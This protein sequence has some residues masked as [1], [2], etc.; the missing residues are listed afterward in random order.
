MKTIN[1]YKNLDYKVEILKDKD[2]GG[3]VALIPELKGRI[4][5]GETLI[6]A[7][8][9]LED[10]KLSWLEA[11]LEDGYDIPLPNDRQKESNA[12]TIAAINEYYEIHNNPDKYPRYKD[13]KDL[14][15]SVFDEKEITTLSK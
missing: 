1:Y 15:K 9:A 8:E 10:A 13:F 5:C 11:A 14:L 4:T 3:F 2:E 12:E 7:Y 6:K